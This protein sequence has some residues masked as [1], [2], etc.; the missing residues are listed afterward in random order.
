[1]PSKEDRTIVGF[2]PDCRWR[3]REGT[4]KARDLVG[5]MLVCLSSDL[6]WSWLTLA[7]AGSGYQFPS[8]ESCREGDCWHNLCDESGINRKRLQGPAW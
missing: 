4:R 2:V 8:G 7:P 3:W 6:P 1:M 5:G